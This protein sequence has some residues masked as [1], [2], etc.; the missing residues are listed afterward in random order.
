MPMLAALAG[1]TDALKIY[2]FPAMIPF[3][4]FC[5]FALSPMLARDRFD[6][7]SMVLEER[8]EDLSWEDGR[9]T[10]V[11]RSLGASPKGSGGA[12][13]T[14]AGIPKPRIGSAAAE[15]TFLAEALRG[16]A[17]RSALNEYQYNDQQCSSSGQ[18]TYGLFPED[19]VIGGANQP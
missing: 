7:S 18:S 10:S 1:L 4:V 12:C 14:K 5:S 3:V 9:A 16:S 15:R 8:G 13:A 17:R 11:G 2:E 19:T 6:C